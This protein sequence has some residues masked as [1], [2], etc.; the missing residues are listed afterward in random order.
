ML[1]RVVR[2]GVLAIVLA[3][4]L[5]SGA[6]GPAV[7]SGDAPPRHG[8][9]TPRE[10]YAEPAQLSSHDG[11]GSDVNVTQ[12]F[13]LSPSNPGN[14]T[15]QVRFA[16]PDRVVSLRTRVPADA[17]V[18]SAEGFD[19]GSDRE[20]R[21]D[22]STDHPSLTYALPVNESLNVTGPEG[23]DG[24]YVSVDAGDWAL[25]RR[26]PTP[27]NWNYTGD[28]VGF[29]RQTTTT[30]SGA[31]GEW[32]VFL[33]EH[34]EYRRTA[35]DQQFRLVVPANANMTSDPDTVLDSMADASDALRVG[36]RD[37]EVFVVAAPTDGVGWAVRGLQTGE[38]DLWVRD[39]EPVTSPD[40][41][42][43][44]EY[45]HSRQHF[46]LEPEMRWFR[47][48][49]ASYYAALLTFEQERIR[50]ETFREHIGTGSD[51]VYADAVLANQSTWQGNP[52][53]VKG[54]LVVGQL[55]RLIRNARNKERTLQTV[56]RAMNGQFGR[57]SL[58]DFARYLD[59]NGDETVGEVGQQYAETTGNVSL[60]NRTA[61][62]TA[63]GDL[64]ARIG[65]QLPGE[66][67]AGT[68]HV[69]SP[70][71]NVTLDAA[72]G[73][74][75]V[76]PGEGFH[77]GAVVENAGGTTGDYTASLTVNGTVVD[78]TNGTVEPNETAVA[79]LGHVFDSTGTYHVGLD[80]ENVTVH[81]REP[82]NARILDVTAMPREVRQGESVQV[83]ATVENNA[84]LPGEATI[85]FRRNDWTV[86]TKRVSVGPMTTERVNVTIPMKR[87]GTSVVSVGDAHRMKIAVLERPT[88][89]VTES[90]RTTET[91]EP[92]PEP[93]PATTTK[94]PVTSEPLQEPVSDA[95]GPGF[96]GRAVGVTTLLALAL[97][98]LR[99]RR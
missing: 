69:R 34:N 33:G 17:P 58:S 10:A 89:T 67:N 94:Q 73:P 28:T 72:D 85:V 63:F 57:V 44:H 8:D 36:N 64:P 14:V 43:I 47:E 80:G 77:V 21:W 16:I 51:P 93:T 86:A 98:L 83:G 95:N 27:T 22:G 7:A 45:V 31:A 66:T 48:A 39:V 55:D 1:M 38:A 88:R 50:Y 42:W 18:T 32:L 37:D 41:V 12:E 84:T 3:S 52:H 79:T 46:A 97:V 4:L 35:S 99:Q 29:D 11:D 68:Y 23:A 60:W 91:P 53:Y 87:E 49:S 74:I 25:F 2:R 65:F 20:Y 96:R 24:D 75:V 6:V 26:P 19:Q 70:Y 92:T 78:R 13:S 62:V 54:A 59:E 76:V 30:D 90:Y 61:H 15:V 9:I 81:V 40:N 71:R 82:A 5:L 56:F